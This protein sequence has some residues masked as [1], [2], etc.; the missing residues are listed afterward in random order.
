MKYHQKHRQDSDGSLARRGCR[1]S[2][3]NTLE[4]KQFTLRGNNIWVTLKYDNIYQKEFRK[5]K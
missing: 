4:S 1:L 5:I 2:L 3:K